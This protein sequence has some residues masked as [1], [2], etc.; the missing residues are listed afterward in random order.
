MDWHAHEYD[1][2][3]GCTI[4]CRGCEIAR[5]RTVCSELYQVL[6]T[7]GAPAHVL[8]Q[9]LAAAEG[10]DLPAVSLLPFGLVANK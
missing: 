1:I 9:A 5:L 3:G 6:G 8:D 7:L 4:G 2:H 10:R